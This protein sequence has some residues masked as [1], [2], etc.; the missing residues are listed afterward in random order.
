MPVM[1]LDRVQWPDFCGKV[2]FAWET[3][4]IEG[5]PAQSAS[6]PPLRANEIAWTC[7]PRRS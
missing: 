6:P 1:V 3:G 5:E 2:P 4:L 7:S